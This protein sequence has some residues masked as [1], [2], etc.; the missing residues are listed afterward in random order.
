MR[1]TAVPDV[2]SRLATVEICRVCEVVWVPA[3]QAN[4]LPVPTPTSLA[5]S[6]VPDRCPY[7]GAP[8]KATADGSCPYCH[9]SVVPSQ[10]VVMADLGGTRTAGSRPQTSWEGGVVGVAAGV[11]LD[12]LLGR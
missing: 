6:A 5:S 12:I 9:R 7:C 1:P 10:I 3:D 11:V 8:F 4:L 2:E